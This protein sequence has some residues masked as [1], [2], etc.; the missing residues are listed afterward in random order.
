MLP[1][2]SKR[3]AG[4]DGEVPRLVLVEQWQLIVIAIVMV[5]LLIA[6]FPRKALI[7]KLYD[8][9]RL[10]DLTL[11]YIENLQRTDPGNAD[12]LILLGRAKQDK[13]SVAE[14][15]SLT[16]HAIQTGSLRQ[17]NEARLL[18]LGS[19]ERA[20]DE[21]MPANDQA[22]QAAARGVIEAA[23]RDDVP[24]RLIGAF[25]ASAFR[26]GLTDAGASLLGKLPAG[27]R[28][29]ILALYGRQALGNG[30]HVLAAECLLLARQQT[31]DRSQARSLFREGIGA[32]MAASMFRQAMQAADR[33]LGDLADDP[34][35]L[36]YLVQTSLAAGYPQRAA[37]YAQRLVF[38]EFGGTGK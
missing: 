26:L 4:I 28:V 5:S 31:S 10:D 6:I 37:D 35:T 19:Y 30:R 3:Y 24:P 7:E 38:N 22:L 27:N 15:E 20:M 9:D 29:E 1:D 2:R 21:E 34:E 14:M 33:Y 23:Q 13:I 17:R 32:F 18:L 16:S 12:L 8:Q 11:S 25:A 36:R